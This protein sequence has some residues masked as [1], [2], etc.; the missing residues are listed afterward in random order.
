M[1]CGKCKAKEAKDKEKVLCEDCGEEQVEQEYSDELEKIIDD[2]I[3]RIEAL[4][5]AKK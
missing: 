3:D 2:L 1:K 4:E 5:D